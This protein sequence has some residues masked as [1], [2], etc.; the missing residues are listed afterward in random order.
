MHISIS[1]ILNIRTKAAVQERHGVEVGLNWPITVVEPIADRIGELNDAAAWGDDEDK[2][3]AEVA[4]LRKAVVEHFPHIE[5]QPEPEQPAPKAKA[6]TKAKP[7]AP[8]PSEEEK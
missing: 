4:T 1:E 2:R 7:K 8:T 6:K 5:P 3:Q